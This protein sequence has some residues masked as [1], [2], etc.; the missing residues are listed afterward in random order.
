MTHRFR[1]R[2]LDFGLLLTFLLPVVMSP[3]TAA[4]ATGLSVETV[5]RPIQYLFSHEGRAIMRYD[6]APEK[7]KSYVAALHPPGGDNVLRDAP[8]DHLHHHALMYGIT[9]NGVNFWEE[10]AG[11]GVQKS[12]EISPPRTTINASGLP[13][14]SFTQTL[15]WVPASDAFLPN[16]NARPFLIESRT[17]R[18]VLNPDA[19]ETA[20]YW[21]ARFRVGPRTNT[22]VL[23][24]ANY[25]GLGLRFAQEM[26]ASAEHFFPGGKPDLSGNKQDA[27]PHPWEAVTFDR[28]GKRCTVAVF[29]HPANARGDTS[30]FSMRSPFAYLSATQALHREPLVYREGDEF[31]LQYLVTVYSEPKSEQQLSARA[32]K[33]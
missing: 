7:Y 13:E 20:V 10:I 1:L 17:V 6:F 24:G 27:T 30:F 28:S 15:Y 12:V 22:V 11:S 2:L 18:L 16:T 19:H 9:V 32:Q 8:F 5:S 4:G 31:E 26:D 25:H 3:R 14:T 23:T 29:G 21:T 33:W